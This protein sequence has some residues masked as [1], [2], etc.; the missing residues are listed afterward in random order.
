M[1]DKHDMSKDDA[2]RI[3][4]GA[5]KA[6][7]GGIEKGGFPARAQVRHHADTGV[8][9]HSDVRHRCYVVLCACD[10][11]AVIFDFELR[12]NPRTHVLLSFKNLSL[13]P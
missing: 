8:P 3:Q 10:A 5:A 2:S 1:A 6:G 4:G 12:G 11:R 7:G 9:L 13:T